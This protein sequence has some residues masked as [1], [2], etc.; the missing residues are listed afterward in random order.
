[1]LVAVALIAFYG[2]LA[3]LCGPPSVSLGLYWYAAGLIG[4]GTLSLFLVSRGIGRRRPKTRRAAPGP[5]FAA[6][7][8]AVAALPP[9]TTTRLSEQIKQARER[10][11]REQ[12]F[13]DE[14][15]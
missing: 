2:G 10:Q 9:T 8:P 13:W 11:R 3:I 15:V 7:D 1:V 6:A 5:T 12:R 4:V 14:E